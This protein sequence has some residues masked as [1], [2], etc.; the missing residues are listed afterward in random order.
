[1]KLEQNGLRSTIDRLKQN[2]IMLSDEI[3]DEKE[4]NKKTIDEYEIKLSELNAR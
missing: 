2:N 4:K 3:L 1:M